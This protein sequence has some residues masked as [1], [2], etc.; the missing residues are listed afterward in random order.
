MRLNP[1]AG[2]GL[3]F[4]HVKDASDPSGSSDKAVAMMYGD[5]GSNMM[6]S[7]GYHQIYTRHDRR[8]QID[9]HLYN[10][11]GGAEERWVEDDSSINI[12]GNVMIKI[13]KIDATSM[14]VMKELSDFSKQMNDLLMSK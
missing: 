10:I 14:E 8:D 1:N 9:G 4:T 2:G 6:F 12:K 13:G 7:K 11:V 3:E 5:D